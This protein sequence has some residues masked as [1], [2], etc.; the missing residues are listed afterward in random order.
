MKKK[1]Q[2]KEKTIE[3][4]VSIMYVEQDGYKATFTEKEH[5]ELVSY[6]LAKVEGYSNM[7]HTLS[8]A[9]NL[10]KATK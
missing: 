3:L 7:I 8:N 4:N 2:T 10:I 6:L 9:I 5:R 1:Q